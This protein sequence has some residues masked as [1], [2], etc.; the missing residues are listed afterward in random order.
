MKKKVLLCS[1]IVCLLMLPFAYARGAAEEEKT[2]ETYTVAHVLN[3]KAKNIQKFIF[4]DIVL[5]VKINNYDINID[6]KFI[7]YD[8]VD[9]SVFTDYHVVVVHSTGTTDTLE[10]EIIDFVQKH[11]DNERLIVAA[12]LPNNKSTLTSPPQGIDIMSSASYEEPA[13][14][15]L[16]NT[17]TPAIMDILVQL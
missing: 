16:I 6:Q 15:L 9:D 10:P 4:K 2:G 11:K 17:V 14:A 8:T 13:A 12:Y 5:G 3:S 1:S 7:T